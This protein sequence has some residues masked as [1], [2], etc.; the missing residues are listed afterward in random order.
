MKKIG[1]IGAGNMAGAIIKG[2]ISS[3]LYTANEILVS[4]TSAHQLTLARRRYRVEPAKTNVSLVE[5]THAIVLAVKPQIIESVMEEISPAVKKNKRFISIAAGVTLERLEKGLGHGTRLVRV[6]PNTPALLG[7]S[8]TV[9]TSGTHARPTDERLALSVF[10]A[11]GDVVR[12]SDEQLL[13]PVTGLSGSGP[14][15]VY[16]FAEA[17]IAGGVKN[18]LSPELSSRLALQTLEGAA[19]MLKETKLSARELREMVTSPGGTTFAGLNRLNERGFS[20]AVSAAVTA[21]TKRSR[22]LGRH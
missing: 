18:G 14:A 19:A 22:T 10:G 8:M 1:F 13:D 6:M 9:V 4:D 3:K 2:L 20:R 7:K 15:Y 21:A 16:L 17:L 12:V 11:V 5:R